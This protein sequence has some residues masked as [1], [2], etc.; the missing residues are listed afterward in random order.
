MGFDNR[1]NILL[2]DR[3]PRIRNP[4]CEKIK[5]KEKLPGG[6]VVGGRTRYHNRNRYERKRQKNRIYARLSKE[7]NYA[8]TKKNS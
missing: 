6:T 8:N 1:I 7:A 2:I 4:M 3:R 5:N